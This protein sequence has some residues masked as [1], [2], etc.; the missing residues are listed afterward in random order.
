MRWIQYF[1]QTFCDWFR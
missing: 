1:G